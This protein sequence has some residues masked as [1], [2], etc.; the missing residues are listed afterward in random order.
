MKTNK[1]PNTACSRLVGPVTRNGTF[2]ASK[3]FPYNELDPRSPTSGNASRYFFNSLQD[4][5]NNITLSFSPPLLVFL[6]HNIT[7]QQGLW[8]ESSASEHNM[9]YVYSTP[10]KRI[11]DGVQKHKTIRKWKNVTSN[12]KLGFNLMPYRAPKRMG[13]HTDLV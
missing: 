5:A 8:S 12:G 1:R 3:L 9:H 10:C 11:Y 13:F 2:S 4:C 6:S 7:V